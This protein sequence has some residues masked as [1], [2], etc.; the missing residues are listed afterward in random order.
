V[1]L[2]SAGFR[3]FGSRPIASCT[4]RVTFARSRLVIVDGKRVSP[5][6]ERI[7]FEFLFDDPSVQPHHMPFIK[8][9]GTLGIEANLR[10]VDPT[11]YRARLDDF[12][13]DITCSGLASRPCRV[14]AAHLFHVARRRYKDLRI[15]GHHRPGDRCVDRADR[16]ADSRP[17]LVTACKV[18]DRSS[19]T[20]AIGSRIGTRARI[21]SHSGMRSAGR[22][23][24][25][26]MHAASRRP[27]GTIAKGPPR[28]RARTRTVRPSADQCPLSP[29]A[30]EKR[31]Y[32][33]AIT[34]QAPAAH[35][36]LS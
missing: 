22:P 31:T 16:C 14:V 2:T 32:W 5:R 15:I 18:L 12:D 20:A 1:T 17:R 13:F 30:A 19:A 11:Q 25:R 28:S 24:S 10:I 29:Q 7:N 21:G 23:R 34:P 33:E 4:G 6:G 27:G 8:N 26:A 9:L 3:W 35:I 36:F